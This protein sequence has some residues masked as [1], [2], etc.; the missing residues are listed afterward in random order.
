MSETLDMKLCVC[1]CVCVCV[2]VRACTCMCLSL[3]PLKQREAC[4]DAGDGFTARRAFGLKGVECE[5][6]LAG[7]VGD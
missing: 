2:S 5:R 4:C 6:R 3:S 7:G 1:V